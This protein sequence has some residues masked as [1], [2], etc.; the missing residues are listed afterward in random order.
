ML[1]PA[2]NVQISQL[3]A[4]LSSCA[5]Q[6]DQR[7]SG[8]TANYFNSLVR[9]QGASVALL[10]A[11]L[12]YVGKSNPVDSPAQIATD[13][14]RSLQAL[15]EEFANEFLPVV[16]ST[17]DAIEA[18]VLSVPQETRECVDQVIAQIDLV[19]VDC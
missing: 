10:S 14:D 12:D 2:A 4:Q 18:G 17:V 9:P 15:R 11:V 5:F 3:A 19:A 16:Q 8:L 6:T 7:I 1:N 13:M